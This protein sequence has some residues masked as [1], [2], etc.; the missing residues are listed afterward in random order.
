MITAAFLVP[1]VATMPHVI[2]T[3]TSMRVHAPRYL[4]SGAVRIMREIE[5]Y[6]N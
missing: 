5:M 6:G 4:G 2:N 3:N 1:S